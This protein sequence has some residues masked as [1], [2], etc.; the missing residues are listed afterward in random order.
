MN[1]ILNN[2]IYLDCSKCQICYEIVTIQNKFNLYCCRAIMCNDCIECLN[3]CRCPFCRAI[4]ESIRI[5]D[6]FNS[7]SVPIRPSFLNVILFSTNEPTHV[8]IIRE[9]RRIN[10]ELRTKY[11]RS[12]SNS[13]KRDKKKAVHE[14]NRN[15]LQQ[16]IKE[17]IEA[18]YIDDDI[19]LE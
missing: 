9:Q 3:D 13:P 4:I 1:N 7:S 6:K 8:Q 16:K 15:K 18:Y 5:D 10:I 12:H 2:D 19:E 14:K 17:D 11:K